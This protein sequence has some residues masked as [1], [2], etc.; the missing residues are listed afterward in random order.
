MIKPYKYQ[1][2]TCYSIQLNFTDS[3]GKRHQPK[4]RKDKEGRRITAL[5]K[6]KIL[7]CE[8]LYELKQKL[9]DQF[10]NCTFSQ[11]HEHFLRTTK[12]LY[13]NSTC[14]QYDGDLKK[15]LSQ[16]FCTHKVQAL[17]KSD[18]YHFILDELEDRGA[19][20]HTQYRI[21]KT[22]RRILEE[23]VEQGVIT[24]NPARGIKVKVPKKTKKVLKTDEIRKFMSEAK[25]SQ[26]PYYYLWS[27][28]LITG[29]RSGELYALRWQD[30]DLE[31]GIITIAH[32]WTSK[33]GY[34]S[35]KSG[36]VRIFPI[37]PDLKSL[38]L[39]LSA[40][41]SYSENLKG[42]NGSSQ[43][44]SDLVL[45][46]LSSWRSGE[47]AKVTRAF[48]KEIHTSRVSFH[49]L[50]ATFITQL[51]VSGVSIPKVMSLVGHCRMS[52]TDEYLRLAGLDVKGATDQ[53]P[54][55]LPTEQDAQVIDF[56][57]SKLRD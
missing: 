1:N 34:Q 41:G 10:Y 39:E 40:K 43:L 26:H 46:R 2:K 8:Y 5:H 15:W 38:L 16:K 14:K 9:S 36:N 20:P 21:L 27:M 30:I 55:K 7:E 6:A 23:A 24:R 31:K 51:L 17:T 3:K 48:C 28:A 54:Y 44:C 18:V 13:K 47:Q 49:D 22:I 50:R 4:Y 11:W 37:S 12:P 53:L 25:N 33:N 42:L 52:T 19:S 57:I 29:M 32:S 45:P 35:T 56:N